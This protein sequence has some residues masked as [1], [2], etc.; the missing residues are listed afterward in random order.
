M[1]T[2]TDNNVNY[3]YTEGSGVATVTTSS[4]ATGSVSILS[5]FIIDSVTY[6]VTSITQSA[7]S[8]CSALT[9]IS[10]SSSVTSIGTSAFD[11]CS[12]LTNVYF[13]GD[14]PTIDNNNFTISDDTAYYLSGASNTS[15]LTMFTNT[16]E[17]MPPTT[18]TI[19]SVSAYN[20]TATINFGFG[21]IIPDFSIT[22][23][24]YSYS[25][26]GGSTFTNFT[27]CSPATTTSPLTI[28]GLTNGSVVSFKIRSYNDILYSSD[29]NTIYNKYV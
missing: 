21:K 6:N 20:N 23:Y 3:L 17:L 15:N 27:L 14:I 8:G 22:N 28:T 5:S 1:S 24:A 16:I 2:Y 18:P 9:S 26:N 13:L 25:T 19:T 7:F 4:S 29:S 12:S 11:N 10:I